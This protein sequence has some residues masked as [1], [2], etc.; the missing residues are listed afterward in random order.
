MNS[1]QK[2]KKEVQDLKLKLLIVSLEP[3]STKA[4]LIR[5]QEKL[6]RQ[7]EKAMWAGNAIT[8]ETYGE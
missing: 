6:K 8:K 7:L 5:E 2:L 1:Y 4:I 3:N